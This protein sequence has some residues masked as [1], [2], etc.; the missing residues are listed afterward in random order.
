M[1]KIE[2]KQSLSAKNHNHHLELASVL[3]YFFHSSVEAAERAIGNLD[4]VADHIVDHSL[5]LA[6]GLLV[7]LAKE[8]ADLIVA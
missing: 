4:G 2:F 8:P 5:R 6:A 3:D 1:G 7:L